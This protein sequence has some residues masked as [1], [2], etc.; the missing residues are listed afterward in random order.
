METKKFSTQIFEP[1]TTID[2]VSRYS[3]ELLKTA[4]IPDYPSALNGL[5]FECR[6]PLRGIAAAVD[7]STRA[8]EGVKA[9]SANLLIVHHGMF[10]GGLAPLTGAVHRRVR[11]L[12]DNDIAVYSSHIPL[13]CHP[14]LGNNVLL[15]REL[16]LT[17]SKEF[18]W[19]QGIFIGVAGECDVA[20]QA[21]VERASSFARQYGHIVRTTP[22]KEGR[23]T[24]RWGMCSGAGAAADTLKEAIDAGIDTLIVGEGPHWT[25]ITAEE[26]DLV[27]IY[28]GHYATETLGVCALA[29]HLSDKYKV[30]WQFVSAPTGL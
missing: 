19:Y 6:A 26:N 5:Q 20:T 25:A 11:L 15:A 10:W 12:F 30:P 1:M 2:E 7:F 21:L 16:Q 22:I 23:R 9:V 3:D 18:A 13:D 17:P 24:R 27:V 4:S 8:I 28:A 29:R 14:T